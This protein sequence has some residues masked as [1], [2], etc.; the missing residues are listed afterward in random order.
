MVPSCVLAA[1]LAGCLLIVSA[2]ARICVDIQPHI[3]LG[4]QVGGFA[5]ALLAIVLARGCLRERPCAIALPLQVAWSVLIVIMIVAAV[6]SGVV[7]ISHLP[8]LGTPVDATN[9]LNKPPPYKLNN[10]GVIT[11]VS[12]GEFVFEAIASG[13]AWHA[14]L[15][16][17]TA[18]AFYV[19]VTGQLPWPFCQSVT[20]KSHP[21]SE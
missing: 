7:A 6:S 15:L 14:F 16:A 2:S 20:T 11:E 19:A 21:T 5:F 4:S 18:S 13:I 9:V 10:H 3:R 12:R 17:G 8:R 1:L